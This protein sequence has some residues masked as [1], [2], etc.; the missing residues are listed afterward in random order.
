VVW[1]KRRLISWQF[2]L[3]ELESIRRELLS[4]HQQNTARMPLT[5]LRRLLQVPSP[6]IRQHISSPTTFSHFN[7]FRRTFASTPSQ[8]ATFNQ[9]LRGCRVGQKARR[10]VSPQLV[11]RPA[12]KGVCLRVGITKPKKPNSG[13]RKIA[14]CRLSNGI[15]V[16]AYIPGEGEFQ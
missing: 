12:M 15:E 10:K 5:F 1:L 9:V 11:Q 6:S 8:L 14:R 7:G 2:F 4:V 16:T 13:E 3:C